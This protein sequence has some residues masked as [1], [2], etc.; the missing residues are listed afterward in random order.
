MFKASVLPDK[1]GLIVLPGWA[2]KLVETR[3]V[4]FFSCLFCFCIETAIFG[5]SHTPP[6]ET[7]LSLACVLPVFR[8]GKFDKNVPSKRKKMLRKKIFFLASWRLLTKRAGNGAGSVSQISSVSDPDSIRSV[9]PDP[10]SESGSGSTRA[11]MTHKSRKKLR[12]LMFWSAGCSLLRAEGF[13][14]NLDVLYG[15]LGIGKL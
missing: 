5:V 11:K 13:F 15:S 12:N 10:Y 1:I 7:R 14:C 2:S 8:I 6:S 4:I 3:I 9:D